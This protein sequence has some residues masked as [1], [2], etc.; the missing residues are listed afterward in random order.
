MGTKSKKYI[1][2]EP[3]VI[4]RKNKPV[5]V[6]LDIDEYNDLLERLEDIEDLKFIE[7]IKT[8]K[9][10]FKKLDDFLKD[11]NSNV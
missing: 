1:I 6:I 11:Y 2:K 9:L 10:T 3:E 8:E 4:Y 5:S 7:K